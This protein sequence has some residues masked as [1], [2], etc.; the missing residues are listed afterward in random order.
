MNKLLPIV[1]LLALCLGGCG[2]NPRLNYARINDV[3]ISA[4][5]NLLLANSLGEFTDGEWNGIV[6]AIKQGDTYLD[7][8]DRA[9][10]AG[11]P[12]AS[13]VTLIEGL[14]TDLKPYLIRAIARK[15]LSHQPDPSLRSYLTLRV[16]SPQRTS[17][18]AHRRTA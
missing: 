1:L 10:S 17:F 7:R 16:S 11:Q 3:F 12:G 18:G 8:L 15:E 13:Y 6:D 5:E 9:T 4:A 2:S 14:L